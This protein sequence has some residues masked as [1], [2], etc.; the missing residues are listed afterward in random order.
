MANKN[1]FKNTYTVSI[2][3]LEYHMYEIQLQ[4]K[5]RFFN[6]ENLLLKH[7]NMIVLLGIVLIAFKYCKLC[8]HNQI[9]FKKKNK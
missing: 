2:V 4:Q 8:F 7:I 5:H 1:V 9:M 6:R 3:F